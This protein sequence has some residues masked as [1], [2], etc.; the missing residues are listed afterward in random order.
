MC[1]IVAAV[2]ISDGKLLMTREGFEPCRGQW[3][4]PAGRLDPNET[5]EVNIYTPKCAVH[6]SA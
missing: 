5:L 1:Y 6:I 3:Y 4:L 2:V